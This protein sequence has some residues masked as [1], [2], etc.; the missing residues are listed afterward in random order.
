MAFDNNFIDELKNQINIVDVIGREVSLKRAGSGYKGLCPFHSEKT[1][2]FSVNEEHQYYHCFGCGEKGDVI[3]F[4]EKHNNLSFTEAVEKLC[5]DYGIKM[6]ERNSGPRIDYEKYYEINRKAARFFFRKLTSGPN[7]GYTYIRHRGIKDETITKFGLGYA[8]NEWN[9]L[10]NHLKEQGVSPDDMLK[11]GLIQQGR[12]GYYDKFRNRVI[13]PIINTNGKVI[14][15]GGR[16]LGDSKPK[17]LNSSESDIFLKKNNLYALNITKKDISD[18]DKV[19]MVEGYMDVISLYQSGVRNVT[20]SL[21][22]AL[23]ENQGRLVSRYTKNVVLSYDA[24]NAGIN[25]AMR[26]IDI[27]QK[28]GCRVRVLQINDGKDPD[29]FVQ[30]NGKEAFLQLIQDALPAT[31]FRLNILR[32]GYDFSSDEQ[33]LQYIRRCV[34]V[35]E[36][37]SPVEKDMYIRKLA[38]EFHISEYAISGE[39]RADSG[40]NVP[41]IPRNTVNR[42]SRE[43]ATGVETRIDFSFLV[44]AIANREYVKRIKQDDIHFRTTLGDKIFAIIERLAEEEYPAGILGVDPQRVYNALDPE[45][46]VRMREAMRQLRIGPDDEIFYQECLVSYQLNHDRQRKAELQNDLSTAE[47]MGNEEDAARIAQQ[48]ME[49]QQQMQN[50]KKRSN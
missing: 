30:K 17:Y 26:G 8:P 18:E 43:T 31:D 50:R 33:V 25:A 20:A 37:L 24:D 4:V 29:E 40:Q 27:I 49:L 1:P 15:F 10:M 9:S 22:T 16:A 38:E 39:I 41:P 32:R 13:F 3:R 2:S 34:P 21:G 6:P 47:K 7:P 48:L 35:L 14:G 46:E 42:R 11:L 28:A 5:E 45:E 23:T 44:L 36:G 12:K 19:L